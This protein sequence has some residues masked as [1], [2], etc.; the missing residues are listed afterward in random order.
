MGK[1]IDVKDLRRVSVRSCEF[2]ENRQ[3][4]NRTFPKSISEIFLIFSELKIVIE[5]NLWGIFTI[6]YSVIWVG[7][8]SV[9]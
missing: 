7:R 5:K 3:V 4:E 6:I 9:Q 8:K 2:R 1:K